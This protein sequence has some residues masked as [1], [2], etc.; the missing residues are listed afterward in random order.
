MTRAPRAVAHCRRVRAA[1]FLVEALCAI[2]SPVQEFLQALLQMP[3]LLFTAMLGVSLVYWLL[4]IIGAADLNPFDGADGV[5][6]T[7]KGAVEGAAKGVVEGGVSAVKGMSAFAEALAF[8]GL[9]KV[10]VTV[11][12]SL[13]SL[14]AWFL[15]FATRNALDFLPGWLAALAATGVAVVGGLAITSL[16]TKPLAAFFK[17]SHRPGGHGLVG[18]TVRITTEKVDGERGQGEIDDGAGGIT[19]SIR[20]ASGVLV[21]GEEAVILEADPTNGLYWVEPSKV[22]LPDAAPEAVAVGVSN[23][24]TNRTRP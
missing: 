23:G 17:E 7:M 8:L 20:C 22:L 12:F 9:T 2:C 24:T 1:L 15:S 16:M 5:E 3:T 19:V 6:G 13:F 14:F 4:I 10:P 11:S 18:R 21:R